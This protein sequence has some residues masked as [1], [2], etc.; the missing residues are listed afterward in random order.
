MNGNQTG[1]VLFAVILSMLSS[2]LDIYIPCC[3]WHGSDPFLTHIYTSFPNFCSDTFI[4]EMARA[5]YL[6][7]QQAKLNHTQTCVPSIL[8]HLRTYVRVRTSL[9]HCF[10]YMLYVLCCVRH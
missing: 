3:R 8:G 10:M 6:V 5:D 7:L 1:I 2:T 4:N 9:C